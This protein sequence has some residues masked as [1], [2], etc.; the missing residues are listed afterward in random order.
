MK[1]LDTTE[2]SFFK[3]I[4]LLVP[5]NW[6]ELKLI[7]RM[8]YLGFKWFFLIS[9]GRCF[10]SS[11]LS[12]SGSEK[13]DSDSFSTLII[14]EICDSESNPEFTLSCLGIFNSSAFTRPSAELCLYSHE[15]TLA[16]SS[17]LL[18]FLAMLVEERG[19]LCCC[20]LE[21]GDNFS[22]WI[23]SSSAL[24]KELSFDKVLK[25]L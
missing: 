13:D 8:V 6:L 7:S 19:L 11:W 10:S 20:L 4:A 17:K 21:M 16:I 2:P 18:M 3:L 24:D 23:E 9:N 12:S 5:T 25:V 22:S 15:C 1:S 14:C